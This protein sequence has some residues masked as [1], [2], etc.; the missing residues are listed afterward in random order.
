MAFLGRGT[1]DFRQE[2]LTWAGR[3]ALDSSRLDTTADHPGQRHD[4]ARTLSFS[5][6]V[7][8]TFE[9]EVGWRQGGVLYY[10]QVGRPH[11][12]NRSMRSTS[13]FQESE[14]ISYPPPPRGYQNIPKVDRFQRHH[15]G[16]IDARKAKDY[17]CLCSSSRTWNPAS[18]G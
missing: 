18:H 16:G 1:G 10:K 17:E 3:A 13:L 11:Q 6:S 9:Q 7:L 15:G 8:T 2:F 4:W 14:V 5:W 12:E